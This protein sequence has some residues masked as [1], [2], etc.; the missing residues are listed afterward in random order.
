MFAALAT[1]R[2]EAAFAPADSMLYQHRARLAG[3]AAR[4]RVPVMWGLKDHAEAGGLMAYSVN[5]PDLA[6]RAAR[7][8]PLFR[9]RVPKRRASPRPLLR[10]HPAEG[11]LPR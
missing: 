1:S 5:L 11:P 8:R 3:L 4:S 9:D 10:L 7:V 6:R 2:T